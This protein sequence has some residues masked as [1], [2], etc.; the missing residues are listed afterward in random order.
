VAIEYLFLVGSFLVLISIAI[1]KLSDNLGVPALL[2]FLAIGMFTGS[3][4]TGGIYFNGAALSQLIGVIDL[5]FIL[6]SGVTV[7][8]KITLLAG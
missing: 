5:V 4:G 1:A 3:E 8:R 6:F 7:D 2:L